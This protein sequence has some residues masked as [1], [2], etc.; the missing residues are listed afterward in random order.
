MNEAPQKV[1]ILAKVIYY[2]DS[3]GRRNKAYCSGT[4][5]NREITNRKHT[6]VE[7]MAPLGHISKQAD[8]QMQALQIR[9]MDCPW[10]AGK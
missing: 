7:N 2:Q 6:V 3:N 9:R 1:H 5:F 4:L 8:L 10:L